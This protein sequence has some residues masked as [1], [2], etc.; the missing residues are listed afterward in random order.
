MIYDSPIMGVKDFITSQ[1]L[2][3]K[4]ALLAGALLAKGVTKGDRVIIYIPMVPEAFIAMMAYARIGAIHSVVLGGFAASE[5]AVRIDD[6]QPK[7]ILT[8]SCG[9]EPGRIIAYKPLIDEAIKSR[10]TSPILFLSCS[11]NN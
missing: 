10:S 7:A 4:T 3:D 9:I 6:A 1:Q 5:L 11:V 2:R 8:A